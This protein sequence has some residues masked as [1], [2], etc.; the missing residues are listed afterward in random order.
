MVNFRLL[1]AVVIC[2]ICLDEKVNADSSTF[3][4]KSNPR[5]RHLLSCDRFTAK[6]SDTIGVFSSEAL[7]HDRHLLEQTCGQHLE[8]L[9]EGNSKDV[10][11][12]SCSCS[13]SSQ[14]ATCR[15]EIDEVCST[16]NCSDENV[17]CV[18]A[19][20]TL[21]RVCFRSSLVRNLKLV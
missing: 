15:T 14:S 8:D 5:E 9:L 17:E 16:V 1:A 11:S 4:R 3:E 21:V 10:G 13:M 18:N 6:F 7:H 2:T 12:H 20:T 19:E